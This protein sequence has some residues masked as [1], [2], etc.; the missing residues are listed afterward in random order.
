M[1]VLGASQDAFHVESEVRL[2][3]EL[4]ET[5]GE[6]RTLGTIRRVKSAV[7]DKKM[8]LLGIEYVGMADADA[9]KLKDFLHGEDHS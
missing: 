5:L 4:P 7:T 9:K 8:I 2:E 6:V 3:I 1:G